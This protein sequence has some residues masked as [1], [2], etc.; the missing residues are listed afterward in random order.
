MDKDATAT[1]ADRSGAGT[2]SGAD[3]FKI[4]RNVV[5]FGGLVGF[6]VGILNL[7]AVLHGWPL[8]DLFDIL[9]LPIVEQPPV[10][11]VGRKFMSASDMLSIVPFYWT[12]IGSFVGWIFYLAR[13]GFIK[14]IAREKI[15]RY[16]LALGACGGMFIGCLGFLAASNG[17]EELS[18]IFESLSGPAN[19][20]AFVLHDQIQG[21]DLADKFVCFHVV[22][23]VYWAVIG[24]FLAALVCSLQISK[25]RKVARKNLL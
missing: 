4:C 24:F 13:T 14:E 22:A 25:R 11:Y 12:F 20:L 15:Y 16:A 19:S 7:V 17:W 8:G 21:M 2:V 1:S 23:I 9:D 18:E 6:A 10:F 5:G 3:R